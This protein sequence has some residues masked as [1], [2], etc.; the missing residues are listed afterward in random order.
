MK[1][2]RNWLLIMMG[3]MGYS[4]LVGCSENNI[5][6]PNAE[7]WSPHKIVFSAT[8]ADGNHTLYLINDDGTELTALYSN[9]SQIGDLW[10]SPDGQRVVCAV[11]TSVSIT[12]HYELFVVNLNG[13]GVV[14]ITSFG[15]ALLEEPQWFPDGQEI[16]FGWLGPWRGAQLF[17]VRVD[18]TSLLRITSDDNTSHRFPRLSPDGQKVAF[19]KRGSAGNTIWVINVDGSNEQLLSDLTSIWVDGG[20]YYPEWTID[21]QQIIFSKVEEMQTST[22]IID[23]DGNNRKQICQWGLYHHC[24]PDDGRIVVTGLTIVKSDGSELRDLVRFNVHDSYPLLWSPDGAKIGFRGDANQ[25]QKDGICVVTADGSVLKE[26]ALQSELVLAQ[27]G[28]RMFDWVTK[29]N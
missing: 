10:V 29:P 22:W 1:T 19:E 2:S 3:M 23:A 21:S 8:D 20:D 17:R 26:I 11:D 24:S 14:Q 12:D 18:G 27:R 25:D 6:P 7:P 15:G 13:S 16:L 9:D 28:L 5:V 4:L